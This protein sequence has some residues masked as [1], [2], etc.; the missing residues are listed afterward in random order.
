M[1]T[2]ADSSPPVLTLKDLMHAINDIQ[3]DLQSTKVRVA[4]LASTSATDGRSNFYPPPTGWRP[5]PSR[6]AG[7]SSETTPRMRV[8]AP[9]FSGEDPTGWIFR[10]QK[11]FDYFMTPDSERLHLVAML[12][13]HP[14][15]EWSIIRPITV[16]P[17]GMSS[18]LLC[19]K[20]TLVSMF[21]TGLKQPIQHEVNLRNPTTLPSAFALARELEACHVD[22]ATVLSPGSRRSWPPRSPAA[23]A[24]CILPTPPATTR[25]P[26]VTAHFPGLSSPAPLPV[27]RVSAEEKA[28]RNKKG[29]CWCCD[30]KWIPGHNCKR[31]FL[32]LMKPNATDG[33]DPGPPE[34][35]APVDDPTLINS[36]ISSIH[37][38][39]GSPSPRSLKITG[40]V[41]NF[42]VQ[43]LLDS[44]STHNFVHPT[45]AERLALVLHPVP[46]FRV[47]VG[48][49]DSLRC[50]YSCPRTPLMLHDHLFDI[51]LFLLEIHGPDMV[52]GV[53]WLQTLGKVSHD[54]ANMTME[55]MWKGKPV[56]LRGDAPGP[57]PISFSQL[58]L[59]AGDASAYDLLRV[60]CGE[61]NVISLKHVIH[62][63]C[64]EL[65]V[66]SLKHVIHRK[67][68]AE[69]KK[70]R[71]LPHPQYTLLD[72]ALS[73]NA[74]VDEAQSRL[75]ADFTYTLKAYNDPKINKNKTI[76]YDDDN[77]NNSSSAL[78]AEVTLYY[79][80]GVSYGKNQHGKA[81]VEFASVS[82]AMVGGGPS[83]LSPLGSAVFTVNVHVQ[84]LPLPY[85]NDDAATRTTP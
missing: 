74:T 78:A 36:D 85:R 59:L 71:N 79:L 15:S 73:P 28:E 52:L 4:D 81:R 46:P 68:N 34:D 12:I 60:Q 61:L 49:G 18:S 55:F 56:T 3:K 5:P 1:T 32:L 26:L 62:L 47:Y 38:L 30:E 27:V 21:V 7:G 45:V 41:H 64:G 51:D 42:A 35:S 16:A 24:S 63:Q 37:S 57:K 20:A 31:R 40:S 70:A 10:I 72:A 83:A 67:E 23:G 2:P 33:V 53:Q 82:S 58:C 14:A 80:V 39:A 77:N 44:G 75:T 9:R 76:F 48:N 11:Y 19:I 84:S 65:N 25:L 54:Y 13:D 43:V 69:L 8:D 29:L 6:S 22:A 50:S 66:I 17:H